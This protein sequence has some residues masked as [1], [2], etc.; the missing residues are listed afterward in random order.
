[1]DEGLDEEVVVA[2]DSG[3]F[4]A[5]PDILAGDGVEKNLDGIGRSR[6]ERESG[7]VHGARI[8]AADNVKVQ[9]AGAVHKRRLDGDAALARTSGADRH[10]GNHNRLRLARRCLQVHG[11][12]VNRGRRLWGRWRS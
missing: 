8:L 6:E 7:L 11:L 5:Y 2:T 3:A 10:E 4:G 1:M 12:I 9:W